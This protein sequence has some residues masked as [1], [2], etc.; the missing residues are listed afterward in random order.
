MPTKH[1]NITFDVNNSYERCFDYRKKI[2]DISQKV[3]ALHAGGAL[4]VLEI[5]DFIYYGLIGNN[6]NNKKKKD[7]FIMSKG[8]GCMCAVCNSQQFRNFIFTRAKC[9]LYTKRSIGMSSRFW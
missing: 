6:I 8:H 1:N 4:S 5:V 9:I 2:L 7:T 3:S